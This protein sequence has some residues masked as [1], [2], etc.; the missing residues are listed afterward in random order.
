[1]EQIN[2]F[3]RDVEAEVKSDKFIK[4][5]Q[6][7]RERDFRLKIFSNPQEL[8]LQLHNRDNPDYVL[9]DSILSTLL[10]E[11]QSQPK[12]NPF[13]SY[14]IILFKPG[15]FFLFSQFKKR[16]AQFPSLSDSDLWFQIVALF[17]EEIKRLDLSKEKAKIA[18][19][20]LGRVRNKLRSYFS[21][22]FKEL[23]SLKEL[24][25]DYSFAGKVSNEPIADIIPLLE[26]LV[27]AGVIGEADKYIL[28]ASYVYRKSM[29]DIAKDLENISYS[30]IRQRKTRA[31][32]AIASYLKKSKSSLSQFTF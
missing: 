26:N 21:T 19:K 16:A 11:C 5:Y 1:M 30:A 2:R 29:K 25:K 22:L 3:I 9:N 18:S 27:K 6:A 20:I 32:K 13:S 28:L 4:L 24:N 12:A 7:V 23:S 8:I 31:K 14:L 15:L 10:L 17:L